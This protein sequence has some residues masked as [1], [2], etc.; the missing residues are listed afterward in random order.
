MTKINEQDKI[1][2]TFKQNIKEI[3]ETNF[4][5]QESVYKFNT[6]LNESENFI[7]KNISEKLTLYFLNR[8]DNFITI[9]KNIIEEISSLENNLKQLDIKY[10]TYI[11]KLVNNLKEFSSEQRN[12]YKEIKNKSLIKLLDTLLVNYYNKNKEIFKLIKRIHNDNNSVNYYLNSNINLKLNLNEVNFNNQ[13]YLEDKLLKTENNVINYTPKFKFIMNNYIK[14]KSIKRYKNKIN[15]YKHSKSK[16]YLLEKYFNFNP[17]FNDKIENYIKKKL[18]NKNSSS[19]CLVNKNINNYFKSKNNEREPTNSDSKNDFNIFTLSQQISEVFK[20]FKNFKKILDDFINNIEIHRIKTDLEKKIEK[21]ENYLSNIKN[22]KII[23]SNILSEKEKNKL[24]EEN[25]ELNKKISDMIKERKIENKNEINNL[26][27]NYN[28]FI[29]IFKL[30]KDKEI[31]NEFE[32]EEYLIDKEKNLSKEILNDYIYNIYQKILE[33]IEMERNV[34]KEDKLNNN[35]FRNDINTNHY[36]KIIISKL[37]NINE[38]LINNKM[39]NTNNENDI[40]IVKENN[41]LLSLSDGSE[42]P[43]SNESKN[44]N[45]NKLPVEILEDDNDIT[46]KKIIELIDNN[47][48]LIKERYDDFYKN[49]G[50]KIDVNLI[51]N[52]NGMSFRNNMI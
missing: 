15:D 32:K 34:V 40:N 35:S 9:K 49:I 44:N 18:Q 31:I 22:N 29:E 50:E 26:Y 42:T 41:N 6:L 7:E 33:L 48:K 1:I 24:K 47:E 8:M 39:K 3:V 12:L 28:Y 27:K 52:S 36:I 13:E 20:I 19:P 4:N 23:N 46:F 38:Y 25:N 51:D 10:I 2:N 17:L 37:N 14:A 5:Y 21:L 43:K 11:N 16:G 30:L 45:E